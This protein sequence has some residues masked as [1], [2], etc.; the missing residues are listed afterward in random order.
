FGACLAIQTN[1]TSTTYLSRSARSPR[2]L[3]C[4]PTP[5]PPGAS[6]VRRRSAEH[7]ERDRL[8]E[9]RARGGA[10]PP[11]PARAPLCTEDVTRDWWARALLVGPGSDQLAPRL[12]DR[13]D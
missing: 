3:Q 5:L 13:G 12:P 7:M 1:S 6:P 11:P 2:P 9:G 10:A 8:A 4:F